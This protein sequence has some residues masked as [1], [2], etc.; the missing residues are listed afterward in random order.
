MLTVKGKVALLHP[1]KACDGSGGV[2]SL[3]PLDGFEWSASHPSHFTLGEG[4][5]D[6]L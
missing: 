2:A 5:L 3:I 4:A 6:R 1:M